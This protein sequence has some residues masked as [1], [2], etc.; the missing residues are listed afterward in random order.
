MNPATINAT[1]FTLAGPG[2]AAVTGPVT[3][4]AASKTATLTPSSTLAVSNSTH[5]RSQLRPKTNSAMP[6]PVTWCGALRLALHLPTPA[7][8]P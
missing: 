3:Y 8:P 4:D 1:A 5:G 7:R 2:A 6:S